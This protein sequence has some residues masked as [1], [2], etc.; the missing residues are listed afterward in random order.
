MMEH[1]EST[2]KVI[3]LL[4]ATYENFILIGDFSATEFY[5]SIK[6]FCDIY[7]FENLIKEINYFKNPHSLECTD[8]MMRIRS[9][10]FQNSCVIE[11][12]LSGFHKMTVSVQ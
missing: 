7:S 4:S 2:W 9:R 8:L 6:D 12:G 11:T 10:S 5:I 3:H 1:V